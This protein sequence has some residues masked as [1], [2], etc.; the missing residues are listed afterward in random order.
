MSPKHPTKTK[1]H[2]TKS[3]Q[4]DI[5]KAVEAIPATIARDMGINV[6]PAPGTRRLRLWIGVT[7]VSA[8]VFAM[9][10]W[11]MRVALPD[12]LTAGSAE[13]ALLNEAQTDI[14]AIWNDPSRGKKTAAIG[15]AK[16][17]LANEAARV[18]REKEVKA[19]LQVILG[20]TE[21][22]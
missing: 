21:R 10:A 7:A 4:K 12:T 9:W 5:A 11:N 3:I 6:A 14:H 1:K 17:A 13:G 19:A 2:I 20:E 22:L 16:A 18:Q 15:A 8:I